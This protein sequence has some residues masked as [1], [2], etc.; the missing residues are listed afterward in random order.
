MNICLI[1]VPR[2]G[3]T[4]TEQLLKA[5]GWKEAALNQ[6]STGNTLHIGHITKES[7][8]NMAK[9]LIVKGCIPII[10]LRHP[11]VVEQSWLARGKDVSVMIQGFRNLSLFPQALYLP[12]DSMFRE[13][14]LARIRRTL[15]VPLDTEWEPVPSKGGDGLKTAHLRP[16]DT[17]PSEEVRYL[18]NESPFHKMYMR[19]VA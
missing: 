5:H 15:G 18:L 10:P 16:E 17:N 19:R 14:Y 3:T 13:W 7:Q 2:T 11:F 9:R 1:S 4:F 6:K 8:V 12:I